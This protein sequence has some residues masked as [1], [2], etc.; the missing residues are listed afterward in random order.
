MRDR[1]VTPPPG[2]KAPVTTPPR[3]QYSRREAVALLGGFGLSAL[4]TGCQT[5]GSQPVTRAVA[6]STQVLDITQ[7]GAVLDGVHDDGPALQQALTI[8]L[9]PNGAGGSI[10]IPSGHCRIATPITGTI[11][12]QL[13]VQFAG[14]PGQ[15]V[16]V[17]DL[18]PDQEA[19]YI[20]HSV[21]G[22]GVSH[23]V[24]MRD[25]VVRGTTPATFS[26]QRFLNIDSTGTGMVWID[27]VAFVGVYATQ[28]VVRLQDGRANVSK[29][30]FSGCAANSANGHGLLELFEVFG[31]RLSDIQHFILGTLEGPT[32]G[33]GLSYALIEWQAPIPFSRDISDNYLLAEHV[34]CEH[35]IGYPFL[36]NNTSQNRGGRIHLRSGQLTLTGTSGG[37]GFHITNCDSVTIEDFYLNN[38][39]APPG[40][41]Q[42]A[43]QLRNIGHATI[44]N[45][46]CDVSQ[47]SANTIYIGD[48]CPAV[49]LFDCRL[50]QGTGAPAGIR[51]DGVDSGATRV[52]ATQGG[53]SSVLRVVD[54]P[55]AANT[56][57]ILSPITDRRALQA[58]LE[59]SAPTIIGV[60]L[61]GATAAGDQI[62][63]AEQ[64]GLVVPILKD[65]GPIQRGD[66]VAPSALQPGRIQ[67]VS[68]DV[69]AI[70]VAMETNLG[71]QSLPV[72]VS[73]R[74]V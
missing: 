18:S 64:G 43:V 53:L 22:R 23:V 38:E 51:A 35:Q 9:D 58:P 57:L 36:I 55:V 12:S 26:C 68:A 48:A 41:N 28:S 65:S 50:G 11:A 25:L 21:Y 73:L 8:A 10:F 1:D 16:I 30:F 74:L 20:D 29:V 2:P 61:D 34:I 27:N 7:Y 13:F 37:A 54:G 3:S 24:S 67:A 31:A 69:P 32:W 42:D 15:S 5:P 44:R 46:L 33:G 17:L 56:L 4:G 63:C 40:V 14:I 39:S 45:V 72:R 70:G 71:T 60:A 19:I 49:D 66:R 59:A 47:T 52:C 6:Q 62:R